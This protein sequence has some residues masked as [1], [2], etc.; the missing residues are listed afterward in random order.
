[1]SDVVTDDDLTALTQRLLHHNDKSSMEKT[2]EKPKQVLDEVS[3]EGMARYI[4][5]DKCKN[6]IFMS[7]AGI[8]TSAGLPDFRSEGS[9]L[10]NSLQKYQL[11]S[12]HLMFEI[13]YFKE[14]P[15]PFLTLA[16]ALYPGQFKPTPCHYFIRLMSDKKLL[17]RDYT[18]NV[19]VLNKL[20][21]VPEELLVEVHGSFSTAHCIEENCRKEHSPDWV[22]GEIFAERIPN[23]DQCGGLIK[24]DIA[25]FG[26]GPI[27]SWHDLPKE[28]FPKCDL[29][30]VMGTTLMVQPFSSLIDTVP[31]TTPRLLINYEMCGKCDPL[32][33]FSGQTVGFQF[34]YE[35]NYR[36]VAF[37]GSCDEGCYKLAELL[38]WKDELEQLIKTEHKK[39]D[40][41]NGRT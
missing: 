41:E 22:K 20:A 7:G 23:C 25:F 2:V 17:L 35:D 26:E 37:L 32:M 38:G 13:R 27:N 34:G 21:G 29:L 16:R 1:M 15:E 24:P 31:E 5:S 33:K 40:A 12:P 19:D 4:K 3:L 39:F 8:S 30:I 14:R 18:Q 6:V 10:Y 11:P 9:G 36:D 28:D